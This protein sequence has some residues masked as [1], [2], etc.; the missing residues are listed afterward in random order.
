VTID[1]ADH[2]YGKMEDPNRDLGHATDEVDPGVEAGR[3]LVDK[4]VLTEDGRYLGMVRDYDFSLESFALT[5]L[6]LAEG[7]EVLGGHT[8]ILPAHLVRTVGE[9]LII[10][11]EETHL[12][13]QDVK[14]DRTDVA[15]E[16]SPRVV[17]RAQDDVEPRRRRVD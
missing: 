10:A 3:A 13:R 16:R 1:S 5:E 12:A 7:S 8:R 14:A 6:R 11:A 15:R 2:V 4:K 17:E 9:D